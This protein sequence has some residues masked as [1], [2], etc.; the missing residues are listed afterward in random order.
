MGCCL[1]KKDNH[2]DVELSTT[3]NDAVTCKC[4]LTG[5]GVKVVHDGQNNRFNI[6]GS[7]TVISSCPLDCDTGRWEV[8][9]GKGAANIQVGIKRFDKK[10]PTDLNGT[11]KDTESDAKSPSWYMKGVDLKEGD[12]VGVYWDQTDL[13]MLS[14]TVNGKA[15]SSADINRVRPSS[16]AFAAISIKGEGSCS[17]VFDEAQFKYPSKSGKF[18]MIIC[19]TSII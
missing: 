6:N 19:S 3:T 8:V 9:I 18:K 10:H 1:G 13:P 17:F 5:S 15:V 4:G 7:G 2:F 16:D 11:L 14:F 12:V